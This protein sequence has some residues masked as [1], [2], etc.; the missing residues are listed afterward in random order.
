MENIV[1]TII[2]APPSEYEA[3]LYKW[4][5]LDIARMYVGWHKGSVNDEYNH[6]S[7][8]DEFADVFQDSESKLKFEVMQYGTAKEIENSEAVYLRRV[9]AAKNPQYYNKWNGFVERNNY[10]L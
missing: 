6:S 1:E 5:N 3:Y 2:P 10:F 7:T 4:T 8:D 9:N